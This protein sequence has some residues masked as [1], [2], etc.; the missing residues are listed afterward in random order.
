MGEM[1]DWTTEN[2]ILQEVIEGEDDEER[3]MVVKCIKCGKETTMEEAE[4]KEKWNLDD[5]DPLDIIKKWLEPKGR[6]WLFNN[7]SNCGRQK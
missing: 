6:D 4:E 7:N 5:F 3:D 2:G 1:A